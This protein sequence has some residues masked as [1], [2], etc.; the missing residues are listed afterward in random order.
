MPRTTTISIQRIMLTVL[1]VISAFS[2]NVNN[3]PHEIDEAE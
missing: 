2:C 1:A 3:L